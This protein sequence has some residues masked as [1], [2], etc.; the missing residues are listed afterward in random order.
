MTDPDEARRLR[1]KYR[2][3]EAAAAA[4]VAMLIYQLRYPKE[5]KQVT[6]ADLGRYLRGE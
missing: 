1:L 3:R 6:D 2:A 5:S 4:M